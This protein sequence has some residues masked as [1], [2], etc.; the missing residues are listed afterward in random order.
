LTLEEKKKMSK[1]WHNFAKMNFMI[2]F[3]SAMVLYFDSEHE[4][5]YQV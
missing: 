3:P 1:K 2:I 5:E 4:N